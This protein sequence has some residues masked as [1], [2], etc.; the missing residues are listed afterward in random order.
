VWGGRRR[1]KKK[2][3]EKIGGR[4]GAILGS[5]IFLSSLIQI[6]TI[7]S[8]YG[9]ATVETPKARRTEAPFLSHCLV[10]HN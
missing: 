6:Q 5:A 1:K 10:L 8:D 7:S 2:K 3:K 4:A 9:L